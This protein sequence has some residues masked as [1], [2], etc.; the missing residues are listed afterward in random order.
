M[1]K[2]VEQLKSMGF[3]EVKVFNCA[4]YFAKYVF[5]LLNLLYK[6]FTSFWTHYPL[7]AGNM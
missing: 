3:D 4:S 1:E 5:T 7:V 6:L 2:L